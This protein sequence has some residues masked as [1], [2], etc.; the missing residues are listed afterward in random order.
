MT[1]QCKLI[2]NPELD[3]KGNVDVTKREIGDMWFLDVAPEER[4]E[5][6]LTAQY[7]AQNANRKPLVVMLSGRTY[8]LLD[9]QCFGHEKGYYDAWKVTGVPPNISV[10]PSINAFGR[11]HGF[12]TN[13][14]IGDPQK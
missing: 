4:K 5:R 13:G 9:G 11:Y 1:W 10:H 8:F 14:V 2:E 3:A 12:I 6:H 7:F